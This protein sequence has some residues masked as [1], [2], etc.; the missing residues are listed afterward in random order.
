MGFIRPGQ[1][2]EILFERKPGKP[3]KTYMLL[4]YIAAPSGYDPR[5]PFIEGAKVGQIN[6]RVRAYKDQKILDTVKTLMGEK[7]TK[8]GQKFKPPEKYDDEKIERE[9]EELFKK[10]D[11]PLPMPQLVLETADAGAEDEEDEDKKNAKKKPKKSPKP[12]APEKTPEPVAPVVLA[13]GASAVGVSDVIK[14]RFEEIAKAVESLKEHLRMSEE[15]MQKLTED[16]SYIRM[17]IT[18]LLVLVPITS[19]L[20]RH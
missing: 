3:S 13:G 12:E 19:L 16:L 9:I 15:K 10:R 7:V 20:F 4:E 5:M 18:I 6:I 11:A 17:L 14:E 1:K 8:Q 2:K